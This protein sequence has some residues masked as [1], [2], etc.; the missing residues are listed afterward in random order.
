[1]NLD[2]LRDELDAAAAAAGLSGAAGLR[3]WVLFGSTVLLL[4]GLRD[5]VGDVDVFVDPAITRVL[6]ARPG[7]TVHTPDPAD[8]SFL[9]R[10]VDGE[11][12]HVFDDWTSRDPEVCALQCRAAAVLVHGWWCTP[13]QIIRMHKAMSV[14]KHGD[15]LGQAKHLPDIAAIDALTTGDTCV[16]AA[17]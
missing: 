17:A 3:P 9:E 14:A 4:Y 16:R 6:R 1:M 10:T 2:P 7:W 15:E 12:V 5:R 11:T 13:L 8:P